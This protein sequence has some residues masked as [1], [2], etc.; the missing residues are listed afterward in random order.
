M[1]FHL[2]LLGKISKKKFLGTARVIAYGTVVSAVF[3]AITVRNAVAD[4]RTQSLELGRKLAGLQDLVAGSHEYR[5]NGQSVYVSASESG[6][7]VGEVLDRFEAHCKQSRALEAPEWNSLVDSKAPPG[8]KS[9]DRFGILRTD[10]AAAKDGVVLCFTRE[11]GARNFLDALQEFSN[12]SDLHAFGNVRYVHAVREDGRT[13][14]QTVWTDGSFKLDAIAQPQGHDAPGTDLAGVPRPAH[15]VR[16]MTAE[17]VGT[18]YTARIYTT[19]VPAREALDSYVATMRGQG[20][21]PVESPDFGF[22]HGHHTDGRWFMRLETG[23]QVVVSVS[24]AKDDAPTTIIVGSVALMPKSGP[25][26]VSSS[27]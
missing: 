24:K 15:A 12:T 22:D 18:P 19:S 5:L 9:G 2:Y 25:A 7:Q 3:G 14:V 6:D 1:L 13:L 11:N 16:I 17:A 21:R 23:E 8:I 4:V 10:D 27:R 26:V 20:W